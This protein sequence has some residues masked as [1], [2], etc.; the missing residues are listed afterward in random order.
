MTYAVTVT[1]AKKQQLVLLSAQPLREYAARHTQDKQYS[2]E[3]STICDKATRA[4]CFQGDLCSPISLSPLTQSSHI[5]MDTYD[6][7]LLFVCIICM[8]K[9]QPHALSH[10]PEL[11]G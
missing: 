1:K 2:E 6:P 10:Q 7:H 8:I 11:K 9:G 5:K 3:I 4:V